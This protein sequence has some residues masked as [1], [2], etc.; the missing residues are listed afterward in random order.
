M[1]QVDPKYVRNLKFTKHHNHV[2]RKNLRKSRQK[3]LAGTDQSLGK[4]VKRAVTRLTTPTSPWSLNSLLSNV[5]SY[6]TG[7]TSKNEARK[8][9]KRTHSKKKSIKPAANTTKK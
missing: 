5:K 4:V 9:T 3:K 6:F 7:E 8:R 2:A 1:F